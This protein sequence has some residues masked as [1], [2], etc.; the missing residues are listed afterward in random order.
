MPK[1]LFRSK[2]QKVIAGIAGGIGEYFDIDP[3]LVRFLFVAATL[4]AGSSIFLYLIMW[5]IVP[6]NKLQV[7][8]I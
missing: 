3:I 4:F 7:E 1:R 8:K 2:D 6:L 5:I